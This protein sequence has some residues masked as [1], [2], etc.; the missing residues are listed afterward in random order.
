M[1]YVA[2]ITQAFWTFATLM[3]HCGLSGLFTDGFPYLNQCYD[4]WQTLFPK[5]LPRLSSH[6]AKQLLGFLGMEEKEFKE[7]IK[8]GDPSRTMLSAMYTTYWFQ[9]MMVGGD[10]PAPSAMAPRL[11]DSLL[12]DGHLGVVFQCGL[13]LL[14]TRQSELL[15]LKGDQLAEALRTLPTKA[16]H[17]F[18]LDVLLEKAF[19]FSVP[20]KLVLPSDT[21]GGRL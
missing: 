8:A 3:Q 1:L 18:A 5:L 14:K 13:A 15:K 7:M 2:R 9:T 21:S 6:V 20:E 19:E 10:N 16:G 17:G 12:L 11:M 4:I